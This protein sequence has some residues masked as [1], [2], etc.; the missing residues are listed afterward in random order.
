MLIDCHTLWT[1]GNGE[2]HGTNKNAQCINR[3]GQF[4]RDLLSIY[5]FEPGVLT[6][7]K[8]LI[9]TP[10][11]ELMTLPPDKIGKWI[12]SC[13]PIILQSH[14]KAR[15]HNTCNV[16]L[17]STYFHPLAPVYAIPCLKCKDGLLKIFN[18]TWPKLG[19]P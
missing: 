16:K 15:H 7:N 12:T 11:G 10:I 13:C 17:L 9:D 14:Y 8:D 19:V 6:S 3:E 4:E 5:K 18:S 2:R 1:I